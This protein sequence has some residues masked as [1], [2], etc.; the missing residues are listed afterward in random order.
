LFY[1]LVFNVLFHPLI[2]APCPIYASFYFK[3]THGVFHNY[4]TVH[5]FSLTDDIDRFYLGAED[6]MDLI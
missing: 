1:Y 4:D 5:F 2:T 6:R 3:V